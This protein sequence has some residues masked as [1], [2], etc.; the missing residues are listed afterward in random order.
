MDCYRYCCM[1][2]LIFIGSGCTLLPEPVI[3][4]DAEKF[5]EDIIRDKEE[6]R[7][8]F[9]DGFNNRVDSGLYHTIQKF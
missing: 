5:V 4:S 9:L 7:H 8:D 3:Y 2:L 6:V 1:I